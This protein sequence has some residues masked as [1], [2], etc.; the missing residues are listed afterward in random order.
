MK[1]A[2]MMIDIDDS[3]MKVHVKDE[4]VY[5]NLFGAMKHSKDEGDCFRMDAT[6]ESIMDVRR[7]V[8]LST[9]LKKALIDALKVINVYEKK[10]D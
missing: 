3:L 7:Q 8:Y 6:F 4:E 5:F 2:R 10:K 9:P 1:P